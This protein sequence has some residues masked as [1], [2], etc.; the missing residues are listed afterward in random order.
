MLYVPMNGPAGNVHRS[1]AAPAAAEQRQADYYLRKLTRHSQ[2]IERRISSY[3]AAMARYAAN[4]D[5]GYARWVRR[6]IRIE[7]QVRQVLERMIDNLRRRFTLCDQGKVSPPSR[8]G[9]GGSKGVS[10]SSTE[11]VSARGAGSASNA[12][13]LGGCQAGAPPRAAQ[14]AAG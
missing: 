7:R 14:L 5:A 3:E 12:L 13:S 1:S 11:R 6:Q 10:G 9:R 8:R 2:E 4:G